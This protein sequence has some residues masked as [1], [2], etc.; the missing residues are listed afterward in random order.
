MIDALVKKFGLKNIKTICV[1]GAG[2]MGS[3]IAQVAAQAGYRTIL[4]DVNAEMLEKS[5][6]AIEASLKKLFEKGEITKDQ[7]AHVFDRL[8]FT[9]DLNFCTA[10]IIIEAIIEDKI[11]KAKLFNTLASINDSDTI[12]AT[13][14][15]SISITEI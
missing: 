12:F 7:I 5:R 14:T 6:S 10:D 8:H 3:G 13:N 15:S 9:N 1:C 11:E 4:Y 2:T